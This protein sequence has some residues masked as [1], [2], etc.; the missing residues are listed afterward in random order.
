MYSAEASHQLPLTYSYYNKKVFT[1]IPISFV[2]C[3]NFLLDFEQTMNKLL[4]FMKSLR[5][6]HH[7]ELQ[8]ESLL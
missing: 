3:G 1:K 8:R 7:F 2:L 5:F 4:F 6:F